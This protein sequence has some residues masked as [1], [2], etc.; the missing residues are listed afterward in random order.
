MPMTLPL[1]ITTNN[2]TARTSVGKDWVT[3]S[4]TSMPLID[5]KAFY[6]KKVTYE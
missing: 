3:V 2:G 5:T 1:D 4:S 6:L